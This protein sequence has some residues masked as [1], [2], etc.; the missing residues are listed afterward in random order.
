MKLMF[1]FLFPVISFGQ[2][3]YFGTV[4]EKSSKL[5]IPFVSISFIKANTG[6]NTDSL[7]QFSLN[8][9][10][11]K[12]DTLIFSAVGHLT[13]SL[14]AKEFT[15][16]MIIEMDRSETTLKELIIHSYNHLYTL[17]NDY[18][19]CGISAI[20]STGPI[21]QLAQHFESPSDAILSKIYICKEASKSLFRI[22]LYSEDPYSG[23]PARDLVDTVIQVL[24]AKRH[25]EVDVEKMRIAVPKGNFF[26]AIEWLCIPYNEIKVRR[27]S[28]PAG[29]KIFYGPYISFQRRKLFDLNPPVWLLDRQGQWTDSGIANRLLIS[30]RLLY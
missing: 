26:I 15:T 29:Y 12:D 23:K 1:L 24:S 25:V 27:K 17:I 16:G 7:G 21:V 2:I 4:I 6:I 22:R 10:V 14:A 30:A 28:E 9:N 20:P 11:V 5:A 3:N 18:S 19:G 13:V 8:V